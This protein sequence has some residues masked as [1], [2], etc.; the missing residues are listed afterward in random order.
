MASKKEELEIQ[1]K[2]LKRERADAQYQLAQCGGFQG[3]KK[4]ELK[5]KIEELNRKISNVESLI[6]GVAFYASNKR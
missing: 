2:Q 5:A 4:K 6:E 1:V 3:G